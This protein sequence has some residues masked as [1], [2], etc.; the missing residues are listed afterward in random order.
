LLYLTYWI[1][2]WVQNQGPKIVKCGSKLRKHGF[3]AAHLE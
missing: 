3:W 2:E 1:Q